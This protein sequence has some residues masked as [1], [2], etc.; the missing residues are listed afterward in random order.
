MLIP[1]RAALDNRFNQWSQSIFD[2][3]C[4]DFLWC[5]V[6]AAALA[7][8]A[9]DT[10]EKRASWFN[11]GMIVVKLKIVGL[12]TG[13]EPCFSLDTRLHHRLFSDRGLID[14]QP[15]VDRAK[16]IDTQVGIGVAFA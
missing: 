11:V 3:E 15:F 6:G 9:P 1:L 4:S 7:P 5:V 8:T 2:Q 10:Q 13:Y 12:L 16:L 14:E